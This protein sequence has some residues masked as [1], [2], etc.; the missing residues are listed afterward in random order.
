MVEIVIKR[1][2]IHSEQVLEAMCA[3]LGLQLTMKGELK[4]QKNNTH[5]HYKKGKEK[6]VLEVTLLHQTGTVILSV[7]ENRAGEWIEEA[8]SS[9]KKILEGN[10]Q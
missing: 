5:W 10:N 4:S 7:H 6:G 9:L 3:A 1:P 2:T 8:M